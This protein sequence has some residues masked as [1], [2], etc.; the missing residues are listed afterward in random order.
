MDDIKRASGKL[1]VEEIYKLSSHLFEA[2]KLMMKLDSN[3]GS[4]LLELSSAILDNVNSDRK[5]R[6]DIEEI[7]AIK[8]VIADE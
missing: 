8:G 6:D 5:T 7:E 1:T 4:S 2:S 3:I